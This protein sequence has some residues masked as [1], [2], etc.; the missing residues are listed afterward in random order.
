M[1]P[2]LAISHSSLHEETFQMKEMKYPHGNVSHTSMYVKGSINCTLYICIYYYL[3]M[4]IHVHIH[5]C[6]YT[7]Q[8]ISQYEK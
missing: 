8:I 3:L 4:L 2:C 6:V 7:V 1:V 5:R